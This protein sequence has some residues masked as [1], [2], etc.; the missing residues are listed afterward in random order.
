[1]AW[2]AAMDMGHGRPDPQI[3]VT[4]PVDDDLLENLVT[5]TQVLVALNTRHRNPE[6]AVTRATKA[7]MDSS[8]F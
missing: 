3:G 7:L 1:M 4:H 2:M 5:V 6:V 8:G